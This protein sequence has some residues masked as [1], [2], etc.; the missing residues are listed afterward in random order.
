[1]S[2]SNSGF[3]AGCATKIDHFIFFLSITINWTEVNWV[4]G[5]LLPEGASWRVQTK[6]KFSFF[7]SLPIKLK[8]SNC[9]STTAGILPLWGHLGKTLQLLWVWRPNCIGSFSPKVP[10]SLRELPYSLG[11]DQSPRIRSVLTGNPGRKL[12]G[13]AVP[14]VR[15]DGWSLTISWA[16]CMRWNTMRPLKITET[17]CQGEACSAIQIFKKEIYDLKKKEKWSCTLTRVIS[18]CWYSRRA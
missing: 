10:E 18:R 12:T 11:V 6:V 3:L 13:Q 15:H 14:G 17:T 7:F 5:S 9:F 8:I 16:P 2:R 4:A 1:M